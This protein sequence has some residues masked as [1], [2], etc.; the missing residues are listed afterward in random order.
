MSPAP[1]EMTLLDLLILLDDSGSG[2]INTDGETIYFY[3]RDSVPDEYL[4]VFEQ[5]RPLLRQRLTRVVKCY[6][7]QCNGIPILGYPV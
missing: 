7:R 6:C 2:V 4:D 1:E 3:S 5:F